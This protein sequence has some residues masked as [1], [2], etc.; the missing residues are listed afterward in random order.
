MTKFELKSLAE[1]FGTKLPAGKIQNRDVRIAIVRL[2]GS[3]AVANKAITE[4]VEAL[5]KGLVGDNEEKI[6]KWVELRQKAASAKDE[7]EAKKLQKEADAMTECV[8]IDKDFSEALQKL[9]AE[10]ADAD[11]KKVPLEVLY[12]ALADCG[13]PNF[14][15]DLPIAAVEQIFAPVIV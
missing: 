4:E 6:L 15:E 8:Q 14:K 7:K 11:I 3:L 2:Y 5:R 12:E 13:F 10:E 9:H 1:Y